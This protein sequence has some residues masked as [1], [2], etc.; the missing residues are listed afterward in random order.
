MQDPEAHMRTT[1][2]TP[3]GSSLHASELGLMQPAQHNAWSKD[4]PLQNR[5]THQSTAAR[6]LAQGSTND[7]GSAHL[8]HLASMFKRTRT[9]LGPPE[10]RADCISPLEQRQD[11]QKS[12]SHY[13]S[14]KELSWNLAQHQ[15]NSA[16]DQLPCCVPFS[17]AS[18]A[19]AQQLQAS[20]SLSDLS[21]LMSGQSLQLP[22]F[23]QQMSVSHDMLQGGQTFGRALHASTSGQ[24]PLPCEQFPSQSL[25]MSHSQTSMHHSQHSQAVLQSVRHPSL[26]SQQPPQP[27]LQ[28]AFDGTSQ[29]HAFERP[30]GLSSFSMPFM[31][32]P[33]APHTQQA[34]GQAPQRYTSSMAAPMDVCQDH[35]FSSTSTSNAD[36]WQNAV[37]SAAEQTVQ[38]HPRH[39]VI[40]IS[41]V[42]KFASHCTAV[43][44]CAETCLC[45][46]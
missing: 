9:H 42:H 1:Q 3:T 25:P 10:A 14:E 2:S 44:L 23:S 5:T 34:S 8:Q 21:P 45:L 19:F 17:S 24:D 33:H 30:H 11:S 39:P 37:A 22:T 46:C 43:P 6:W 13:L 29:R 15:R 40:L 27:E 4:R 7:E 35:S 36:V 18:C 12:P 20:Q 26:A 16:K 41:Q 31:N 38:P 28:R 32:A